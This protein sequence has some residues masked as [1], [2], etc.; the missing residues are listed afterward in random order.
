MIL[1]AHEHF[2][3]LYGVKAPMGLARLIGREPYEVALA[4]LG[5]AD[6][7][8]AYARGRQMTIDEAV[9]LTA[10]IQEETWGPG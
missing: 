4:R 5:G 7:E 8:A 10:T 6:Y 9:A 1:G 2:Q 3:E